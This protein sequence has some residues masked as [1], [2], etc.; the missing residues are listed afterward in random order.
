[1]A[2]PSTCSAAT[3]L[4]SKK[5]QSALCSR[6]TSARASSRSLVSGLRTRTL[7]GS[8]LASYRFNATD[9]LAITPGVQYFDNLS[10]GSLVDFSN[11]DAWRAGVTLD[12]KITEGL[13]TRVSVQYEDADGS[14]DQVFGFVRLQRD[15]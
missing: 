9:K 11:D 14:D 8:A 7:T 6:L 1:V 3:T 12:Y 10:H 2:F 4:N 15:F 13:A 5:A